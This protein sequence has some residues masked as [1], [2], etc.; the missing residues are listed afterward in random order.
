VAI[1]RSS[2]EWPEVFLYEL[3]ELP[4]RDLNLFP[5]VIAVRDGVTGEKSQPFGLDHESA[6]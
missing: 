1:D 2:Q 6:A 3:G 5:R 4:I